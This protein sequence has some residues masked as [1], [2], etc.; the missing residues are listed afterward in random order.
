MKDESGDAAAFAACCCRETAGHHRALRTPQ[1]ARRVSGHP[2]PPKRG[3]GRRPKLRVSMTPTTTMPSTSQSAFP[4][5]PVV[6]LSRTVVDFGRAQSLALQSRRPTSASRFA[7]YG[8]R[9]TTHN[10]ECAW[11]C[12]LNRMPRRYLKSLRQPEDLC[13][14][15]IAVGVH[16]PAVRAPPCAA[17]PL[18]SHCCRHHQRH[19]KF[20]CLLRR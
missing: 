12:A 15:L 5:P 7:P 11:Y 4:P 18:S 2:V 14:K 9:C 16:A 20:H 13:A 17:F 3:R 10:G 8:V 19:H 1:G 6:T